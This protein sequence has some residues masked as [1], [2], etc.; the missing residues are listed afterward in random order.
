MN[1]AIAEAI[2]KALGVEAKNIVS[3]YVHFSVNEPTTL[4]IERY[5]SFEEDKNLS[6]VIQTYE[7]V[8]KPQLGIEM[9]EDN[10][11]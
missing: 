3:G 4:T 1:N 11:G 9:L 2:L 8:E 5:V 10:Q 7:L 6:T